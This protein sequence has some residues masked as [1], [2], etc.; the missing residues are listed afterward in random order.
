M[1]HF[2]FGWLPSNFG[3][4]PEKRFAFICFRINER[5]QKKVQSKRLPEWRRRSFGLKNKTFAQKKNNK[6]NKRRTRGR[7]PP[8]K[9]RAQKPK[10]KKEEKFQNKITGRYYWVSNRWPRL[11]W[12]ELPEITQKNEWI[13]SKSEEI[14]FDFQRIDPPLRDVTQRN[15][16]ELNS[17]E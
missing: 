13:L 9:P 3:Q 14:P 1:K 2:F 8:A 16:G 17:I 15:G 10:K 5:K 12:K 4:T 7:A 6:K 11:K